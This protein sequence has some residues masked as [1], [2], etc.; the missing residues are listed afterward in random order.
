MKVKLK[1]YCNY[2]GIEYVG[3]APIGP[4]DEL[5]NMIERREKNNW[6]S[7]M[8]EEKIE[9]RID[10][11]LIMDDCKSVIVCLFPYYIKDMNSN[12]S[13]Y[14]YALDYHMVVKEKLKE[15]GK[16]LSDEIEGF[17]YEA[18][19][20]TGPLADRYLAYRAGLGFFGLNQ[21]LIN[22]KYGTYTFIGYMI[23]NYPFKE[24]MP[25]NMTCLKCRACIEA[26]PGEALYDDFSMNAKKCVSYL[27]QK[28]EELTRDEI[29]KVKMAKKV[30]GCDI[31]QQVCPHNENIVETNI[32]EFKENLITSLDKGEI[33][34][35]S[36][37]AFKR[38][39]GNRAFGWRGRKIISR[40]FSY[41]DMD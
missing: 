37:K 6:L 27:T 16:Y 35:M 24:D 38:K 30:F 20:D 10:P 5:K 32:M 17:K 28:K 2:M 12:I 25:L 18:F 39:Y 22:D 8:E 9:R 3:I 34:N 15:I 1:K 29:K 21:S 40:N 14:T 11:K 23:N 41:M 31:C 4:Y 19:V 26:C 36:N 33:D 13:N 7:G